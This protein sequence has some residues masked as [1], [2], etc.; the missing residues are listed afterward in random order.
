MNSTG[1]TDVRDQREGERREVAYARCPTCGEECEGDDLGLL[2]IDR[3]VVGEQIRSTTG[4]VC[5]SCGALI[6]VY[7]D[8]HRTDLEEAS[9]ETWG[10]VR[11]IDQG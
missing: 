11:S 6:G 4:V 9:S 10:R 8:Y 2:E 1:G 3:S 7:S 5:R